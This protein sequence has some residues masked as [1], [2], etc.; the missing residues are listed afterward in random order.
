M[1]TA[2]RDDFFGKT[3]EF[4]NIVSEL[5]GETDGRSFGMRGNEMSA[6]GESVVYN[7]DGVVSTA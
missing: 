5:G 3:V 1:W 6:F 2:I 4:P 7:E